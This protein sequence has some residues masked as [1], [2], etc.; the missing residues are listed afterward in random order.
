MTAFTGPYQ[1]LYT[2]QNDE[3]RYSMDDRIDE[4]T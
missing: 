2:G 4:S 3:D 1:L